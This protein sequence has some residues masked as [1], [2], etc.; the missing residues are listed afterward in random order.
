MLGALAEALSDD[1]VLFIDR[2]G[3]SFRY[4]LNYLRDPFAEAAAPPG[5]DRAGP[6]RARGGFLWSPRATQP[7]FYDRGSGRLGRRVGVYAS[8]DSG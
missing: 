1:E 8:R 3:P 2:D 4:V 7:P 5:P 6:A